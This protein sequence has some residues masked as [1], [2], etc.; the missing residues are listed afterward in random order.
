MLR[1][2]GEIPEKGRIF[3]PN[4]DFS[5]E[6]FQIRPLFTLIFDKIPKFIRIFFYKSLVIFKVRQFKV[7]Y[8]MSSFSQKFI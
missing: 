7:A 1:F 8:I 5:G 6:Y 4:L 2:Y 3:F